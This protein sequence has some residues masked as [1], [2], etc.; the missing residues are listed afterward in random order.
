VEPRSSLVVA[1]GSA[2]TLMSAAGY[3]I[4]LGGVRRAALAASERWWASSLRDLVNLAGAALLV[5]SLYLFGFTPPMAIL[6]GGLLALSIYGADY[7]AAQRLAHPT[8]TV[9]PLAS[10]F[11]GPVLL[12]AEDI[13]RG[14]EEVLA[15]A[16]SGL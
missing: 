4:A 2:A 11:T 8:R 10:L 7:A 3:A 14:V 13:A 1:L 9:A 16:F 6:L 15:Q 12:F 5:F